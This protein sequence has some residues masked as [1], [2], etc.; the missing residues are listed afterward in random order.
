MREELLDFFD[1]IGDQSGEYINIANERIINS[2]PEPES[3]IPLIEIIL[4]DT[5]KAI[6]EIAVMYLIHSL[7]I[8]YNSLERKIHDV[9]EN[10]IFEIV[11]KET[12][13]RLISD[14][15]N[16]IYLIFQTKN[17]SW[18]ALDEFFNQEEPD[19]CIFFQILN[20]V[21]SVNPIFPHSA[22]FENHW[23]KILKAL[24]SETIYDAES[25]IVFLASFTM[26]NPSF[27]PQLICL[28]ENIIKSLS[29][30]LNSSSF[31]H[32]VQLE[33][34]IVF[35]LSNG[36]ALMP[37]AEEIVTMMND[38]KNIETRR[39][40][41]SRIPAII[42]GASKAFSEDLL[43]S[44]IHLILDSFV[45]QICSDSLEIAITSSDFQSM[46]RIMN[47]N[48]VIL[49]IQSVLEGGTYECFFYGLLMIDASFEVFIDNR[50]FDGFLFDMVL[51]ENYNLRQISL[52]AI[53]TLVRIHYNAINYQYSAKNI[54][55][56]I[57]ECL[58][59]E[60]SIDIDNYLEM[61]TQLLYMI[62]S[63]S[64]GDFSELYNGLFILLEEFS[65]RQMI[66]CL[67]NII[68]LLLWFYQNDNVFNQLFDN[69]VFN[70]FSTLISNS[71]DFLRLNSYKFFAIISFAS[72]ESVNSFFN[73]IFPQI[74]SDYSDGFY[75]N[76]V[77]EML[78][79]ICERLKNEKIELESVNLLDAIPILL[80]VF[81]I[82]DFIT[83][84]RSLDLI[85]QL[86]SLVILFETFPESHLEI[87][88]K[89]WNTIEYMLSPKS[90]V[91]PTE[92]CGLI[93]YFLHYLEKIP[94]F[95]E[96][97]KNV[98][99][100]IG[101]LIFGT[102]ISTKV[103][104]ESIPTLLSIV[105]IFIHNFGYSVMKD[106]NYEFVELAL[107]SRNYK[108]QLINGFLRNVLADPTTPED[109]LET[110]YRSLYIIFQEY[111]K[112]YDFAF[113]ILD[114][115]SQ[116]NCP[117]ELIDTALTTAINDLMKKMRISALAFISNLFYIGTNLGEETRNQIHQILFEEF[118]NRKNSNDPIDIKTCSYILSAL[119]DIH[120]NDEVILRSILD[121]PLIHSDR[122]TSNRVI[123]FLIKMIGTK[124]EEAAEILKYFANFITLPYPIARE[125]NLSAGK[126]EKIIEF[127]Y[128]KWSEPNGI[129]FFKDIMIHQE[130]FDILNG[131]MHNYRNELN[132]HYEEQAL[133]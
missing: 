114:H 67:K 90:M 18:H 66:Q 102:G 2:S 79:W 107:K 91:Y 72:Q 93:E 49:I 58:K 10:S 92:M 17:S 53:D 42:A 50:S 15:L 133:E 118:N 13:N 99:I 94:N 27:I 68:S 4:D 86:R 85:S 31:E 121:Y 120:V 30:I 129:E 11:K 109:I 62:L 116:P 96:Q 77:L 108:S 19:L 38:I 112:D 130:R 48:N 78:A 8:L 110:I 84:Q 117:P 9:L 95:I 126:T 1:Q 14:E 89:G 88:I 24:E 76:E 132:S 106:T 20:Y 23:D 103:K 80:S 26:G 34:I 113:A 25:A 115:H 83:E 122:F 22:I 128:Q 39:N 35:F 40:S 36:L 7:G 75:I 81:D 100:N 87:L 47:E 70:L 74:L 69:Q 3:I 125:A 55:Q 65:N 37:N 43:I 119:L 52:N 51:C 5:P 46:F 6:H 41:L 32:F 21:S 16:I 98:I 61:P 63:N 105:G 82:D 54:I 59:A 123:K 71:D 127:I 45:D 131:I 124:C 97:A 44:I 29:R 33:K 101:D 28:R 12:N 64:L 56:H 60:N 111:P 73:S 104:N 57:N